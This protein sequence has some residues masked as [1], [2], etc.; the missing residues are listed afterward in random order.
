MSTPGSH[1]YIQTNTQIHSHA[2]TCTYVPNTCEHI[3]IH[4]RHTAMLGKIKEPR[5]INSVCA[6]WGFPPTCTNYL[7]N[8]SVTVNKSHLGTN[9]V[10]P[11]CACT[12][13][14]FKIKPFKTPG[15][16][17]SDISINL[18]WNKAN[19]LDGT[20]LIAHRLT[21]NKQTLGLKYELI[22]VLNSIYLIS[23]S[24]NFFLHHFWWKP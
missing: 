19:H 9:A 21:D 6:V 24:I 20:D 2:H 7:Q 18:F 17:C 3:C 12:A 15:F 10:Y 22:T 1:A 23:C 11:P 14:Q 5:A 16:I 8:G 13:L 4:T